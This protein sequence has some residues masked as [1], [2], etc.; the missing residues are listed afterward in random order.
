[1][2]NNQKAGLNR[3][4]V[5]GGAA[6]AAGA[7]GA[8][9]VAS[10]AAAGRGGGR[11]HGP[12]PREYVLTG[13]YVLSM[14]PAV[15]N[16]AAGDI[17]IEGERIAA[18][19]ASIG[20]PANHAHA[21]YCRHLLIRPHDLRFSGLPNT[22]SSRTLRCANDSFRDGP[23]AVPGKTTHRWACR[24]G[25]LHREELTL[26]SGLDTLGLGESKERNASFGRHSRGAVYTWNIS[27]S[28][29]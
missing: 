2:E 28:S 12:G 15:G 22:D 14:D 6:A 25:M 10:P 19:G 11:D 18:I 16:F 21:S 27:S 23:R 29:L 9:A 3:R 24:N 26:Q 1:M 4:S 7:L 17:L 20:L 5:L 13:G 8:T